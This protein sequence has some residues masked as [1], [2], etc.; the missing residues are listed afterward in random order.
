[1]GQCSRCC[2]AIHVAIIQKLLVVPFGV[3]LGQT[4][5]W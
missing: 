4:G 1:L 5:K 2:T 3:P